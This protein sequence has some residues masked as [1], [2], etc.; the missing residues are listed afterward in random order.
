MIGELANMPSP[1][2]TATV[3]SVISHQRMIVTTAH[4]LMGNTSA[5]LTMNKLTVLNRWP[6]GLGVIFIHVYHTSSVFETTTNVDH[7]N[8]LQRQMLFRGEDALD[9]YVYHTIA[10][11][12]DFRSGITQILRNNFTEAPNTV[13]ALERF[14]IAPEILIA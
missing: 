10:E 8:R 5:F 6:L 11:A 14:S 12:R 13:N 2:P 4:I 9:L 1:A 7:L 3:E